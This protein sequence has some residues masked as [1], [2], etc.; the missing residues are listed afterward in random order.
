MPKITTWHDDVRA[1]RKLP[2]FAT[3]LM[4]T[5]FSMVAWGLI[6]MLVFG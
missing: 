3:L 4:V 5:G 2:P 1:E 6:I